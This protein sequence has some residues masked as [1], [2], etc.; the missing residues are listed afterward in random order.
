MGL[1][2]EQPLYR[3]EIC[4]GFN[5]GDTK[6]QRFSEETYERIITN[7]CRGYQISYSVGKLTGGY[8]HD[9]GTF[10][11]ENS[12]QIILIGATEEQVNEIAKDLCVFFNQESVLVIKSAATA[13]LVYESLEK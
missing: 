12:A 2:N 10:V 4:V 7:I 1:E 13:K 8:V 3:Y 11:K 9:D 6:E 5:D